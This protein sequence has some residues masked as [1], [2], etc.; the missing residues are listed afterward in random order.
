MLEIV[1]K[2]AELITVHKGMSREY[3]E[4]FAAVNGNGSTFLAPV[5]AYPTT[6]LTMALWNGEE[7]GGPFYVIDTIFSFLASGTPGAGGALLACVT[8]NRQ[9]INPTAYASTVVGSLAGGPAAGASAS[10]AGRTKGVFANAITLAGSTPPWIVAEAEPAAGTGATIA[11][12]AL[13][14]KI[15]GRMKVPPGGMLG[16]TYLS[17]AGT[18]PLYGYG[19]TWTQ[20]KH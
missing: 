17:G 20:R 10:G 14:A 2:L 16:L 15:D 19:V 6:T 7:D 9:A 8:T 11:T 13:V 12:H 3:E 1:S 5:T 18:T 4:T